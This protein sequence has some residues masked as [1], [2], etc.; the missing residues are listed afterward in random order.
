VRKLTVQTLSIF[1]PSLSVPV[2]P[3]PSRDRK[4]KLLIRNHQAH[5]LKVAGSNPAPAPNLKPPGTSGGFFSIGIYDTPDPQS[6][7]GRYELIEDLCTVV[8]PV[9][10]GQNPFELSCELA[11][12]HLERGAFGLR[13]F[14]SVGHGVRSA[15]F[16]GCRPRHEYPALIEGCSWRYVAHDRVR[17]RRGPQVFQGKAASDTAKW[18]IGGMPSTHHLEIII[19]S[20]V[21]AARSCLRLDAHRQPDGR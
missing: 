21:G 20:F 17:D 2:S 13:F 18:K 3:C 6:P 19:G 1:T 8:L 16:R 15:S 5:N 4:S 10:H 7:A 12:P 14:G 11:Q 9:N